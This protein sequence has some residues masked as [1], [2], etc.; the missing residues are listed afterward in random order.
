[1]EKDLVQYRQTATRERVSYVLFLRKKR[2]K[3]SDIKVG[4]AL[5][6][7]PRIAYTLW[8]AEDRNRG[9]RVLYCLRHW[10]RG[11]RSPLASSP[12]IVHIQ[13]VWSRSRT[14]TQPGQLHHEQTCQHSRSSAP[15]NIETEHK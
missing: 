8:S 9:Q 10:T 15:S 14:Q 1:M 12:R 11:A 5:E 4:G 13:A 3:E 6:V 2:D 7:L